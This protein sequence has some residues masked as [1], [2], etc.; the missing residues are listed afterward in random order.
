M[1]V[2]VGGGNSYIKLY[3]VCRKD[4]SVAPLTLELRGHLVKLLSGRVKTDKRKILF[5]S[6]LNKSVKLIV[7]ICDGLKGGWHIHMEDG[8]RFITSYMDTMVKW[9]L[10]VQSQSLSS[11]TWQRATARVRLLL[12]C[13]AACGL[14]WS[15]WLQ[16]ECWISWSFRLIQ[17]V[18]HFQGKC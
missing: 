2:C 3:V 16:A 12:S 8:M 14:P 4:I 17:Q 10:S 11:T 18:K 9:N 7:S 6:M 5:H 13:S 15:L 1:G